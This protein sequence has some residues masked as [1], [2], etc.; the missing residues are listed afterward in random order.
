MPF[1]GRTYTSLFAGAITVLIAGIFYLYVKDNSQL[2]FLKFYSIIM[3]I[4]ILFFEKS[5]FINAGIGYVETMTPILMFSAFSSYRVIKKFN[6]DIKFVRN[7]IF[8]LLFIL[9]AGHIMTF[10]GINIPAIETTPLSTWDTG[11]IDINKVST[12]RTRISSFVG[13]SGPYSISL[14]YL[15]IALSIV[16]PKYKNPILFFGIIVEILSFTRSGLAIIIVYFFFSNFLNSYKLI[17]FNLFRLSKKKIIIYTIFL[18]FFVVIFINYSQLLLALLN[19]M[20]KLFSLLGDAGNTD[21]LNRMLDAQDIVFNTIHSFFIG[22]GTGLTSRAN[23]SSQYESQ[24]VKIFI[25]WGLI[26]FVLFINWSF[27][28]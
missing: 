16:L 7:L 10:A 3:L 23:D 19:R 26:G 22:S 21:R 6:F 9:I 1:V 15:F 20:I 5:N 27:V 2:F 4:P 17:N 8:F 14:A 28:T 18:I 13:T 11:N 24:I 12:I 25:E